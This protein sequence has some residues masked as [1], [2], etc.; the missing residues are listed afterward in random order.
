MTDS[1]GE[2]GG[3]GS[4]DGDDAVRDLLLAHSD[5]RAV[6]AVFEAHTGTGSA[7]P[8]DLIEAARAT[9]GDLALVARDGAADVYVRWNPDRSRYERLSLWPPWTLAGYDHADRAAVESLLE[10]A[11]DVRPV[12]RG[13]TPFASPGTLASLGDPFF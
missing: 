3:S 7:D 6:R 5:H 4:K 8:T 10:D 1:D 11:A 2:N 13:E 12:P 9:D